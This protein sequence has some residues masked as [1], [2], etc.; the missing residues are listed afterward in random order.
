MRIHF[1]RGIWTFRCW[2]GGRASTLNRGGGSG[3]LTTSTTREIGLGDNIEIA[4]V[5]ALSA[6][7]RRAIIIGQK[8]RQITSSMQWNWI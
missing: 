8:L 4:S 6:G 2:F 3:S 5:G 7:Q 1:P